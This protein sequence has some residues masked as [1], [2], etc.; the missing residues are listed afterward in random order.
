MVGSK[1]YYVLGFQRQ[2]KNQ[3]GNIAQLVERHPVKVMVVGSNP[4]VPAN[5]HDTKS[6]RTEDTLFIT[7][8]I[9]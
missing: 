8:N 1:D 6:S 9:M 7:I 2:K 5:Y 4:T 3:F